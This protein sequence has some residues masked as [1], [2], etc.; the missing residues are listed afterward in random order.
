MRYLSDIR[1]SIVV[2]LVA[3]PLCLGIALA[4]GAPLTAGIITGVV[5]GI[6]TGLLS[7]SPLSVSG[8]AAGLVV[9]V[10]MGISKVGGYQNF[11]MSVVLAGGFQIVFSALRGGVISYLIPSS[12]ITGML[13][14]IGIIITLKQFPHLMGVDVDFFSYDKLKLLLPIENISD[15]IQ[16]FEMGAVYVSASSILLYFAWDKFTKKSNINF[17]KFISAPLI[18]VAWGI[19][20]NSLLLP[21]AIKL[22]AAHTLNLP[23][24][25][26]IESVLSMVTTPNWIAFFKPE[27]WQVAFT[28]A[29]IASL[30]TLLSLDAV[31]KLDP[32]KRVSKRNQELFA[33]GVGNMTSGVLGGLP[34]TAVI[35]RSSANVNAGGQ[36]KLSTIFHGFL[37][38]AA[39]CLIPNV[40]NMI[41]FASLATILL[42]TGLKLANIEV[43]KQQ[44]RLGK[45]SMVPFYITIGAILMFDLLVGIFTGLL[46]GIVWNVIQTNKEIFHF[47][48]EDDFYLLRFKKDVSFFAKPQLSKLLYNQIRSDSK[49]VISCDQ[50]IDLDHDIIEMFE[51][52]YAY[53]EKNKIEVVINANPL[54][55]SKFF[56]QERS[57]S[58]T[59]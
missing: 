17:L 49:L 37:I 5:G 43:F 34:M 4:S 10:A 14:A 18:T 40:M 45:K 56:R 1:A 25:G 58:M 42:M 30:E 54:S 15:L 44:N 20:L 46:V 8:P 59:C 48:K 33:Q 52:Y 23:F 55:K 3:I 2:T 11:L 9:I 12:V 21:D 47:D 50:G 41:P 28:I 35:V 36:T 22:G 29:V 6:L 24:T 38:L 27:V 7:G 13:V 19:T 57:G 39:V 26:G 32:Q 31:D 51:N 16:H 53:A